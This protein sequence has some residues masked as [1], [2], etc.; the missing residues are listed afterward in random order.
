MVIARAVAVCV[1]FLVPAL[2]LWATVFR[3]VPFV[4]RA[5]RAAREETPGAGVERGKAEPDDGP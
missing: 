3:V 2:T 4:L 1:M 5:C